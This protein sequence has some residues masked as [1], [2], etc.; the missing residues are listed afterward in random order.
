[1]MKKLISTTSKHQPKYT[2]RLPEFENVA[3]YI[4]IF[5]ASIRTHTH[6][7]HLSKM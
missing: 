5:I 3:K 1:M 2:A 4:S 7:Q 6:T